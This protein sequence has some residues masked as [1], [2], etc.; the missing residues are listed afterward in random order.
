MAMRTR[1][2]LFDANLRTAESSVRR[3]GVPIRNA[4]TIAENQYAD[5]STPHSVLCEMGGLFLDQHILKKQSV[6]AD[7][8]MRSLFG[9]IRTSPKEFAWA[10]ATYAE[11]DADMRKIRHRLRLEGKG[12]RVYRQ[13]E[14][15]DKFVQS[16]ARRNRI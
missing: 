3:L 16:V 5:G 2:E 8:E 14:W 9:D 11:M 12:V 13:L 4:E 15:L 1:Q 6:A 10:F 7:P